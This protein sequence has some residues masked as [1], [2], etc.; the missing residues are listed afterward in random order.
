MLQSLVGLE[1]ERME[2]LATDLGERTAVFEADGTYQKALDRAVCGTVRAFGGIDVAIAN[3]G[4]AFVS[5]ITDA[6][7]EHIER[8]IEGNL[9]G[10]CRTDRAVL[11]HLV[12]RQGYLLNLASAVDAIDDGI[13]SGLRLTQRHISAVPG[14]PARSAGGS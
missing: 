1:P 3:A 4:I 9:L 10:V 5:A 2:R 12:E 7:A 14:F 13:A 8:T 11:P 6:P